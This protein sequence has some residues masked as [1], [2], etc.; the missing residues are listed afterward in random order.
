LKDEF[1][2]RS[3][4]VVGAVDAGKT[5]LCQFLLRSFLQQVPVAY[6]DCDPGQ[7]VIGPPTTLGLR[8]FPQKSNMPKRALFSFVGS[9]SPM[10]HMLQTLSGAKKLFETA[11]LMGAVKVLLDSSGFVLGKPAQ[12]FQF[13]LIDLLQP[14]HLIALQHE[15]ELEPLLANFSVHSQIQIHRFPVV[16][17]VIPRTPMERQHYRKQKFKEYF[18]AA[19]PQ[20][21]ALQS[22][23]IH[24]MVPDLS[25]P[26]ALRNRLIALCDGGNFVI[27]LGILT[28]F[29]REGELLY[30]YSPDFDP[31]RVSSVQVGSI[32]LTLQGEEIPPV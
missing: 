5:T 2:W 7:S 23:G 8:V 22:L 1:S 6:L 14:D 25:N 28:K 11:F 29:E 32:F 30:F 18:K 9:T 24:G 15:E 27:V 31:E 3:I 4:Y 13:Q 16:P 10:G 20:Q 21:L 26:S 17:N 12:E 19:Q